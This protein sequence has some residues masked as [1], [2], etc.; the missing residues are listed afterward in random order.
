VYVIDNKRRKFSDASG[1]EDDERDTAAYSAQNTNI[2]A[3]DA[4]DSSGSSSDESSDDSDDED[5][6]AEL[7]R[8]LEKIRRERKEEQERRERE[9]KEA[10]MESAARA[11]MHG[12]PLIQHAG[13]ED[14]VVKKKWY[15]DTV[16]RN[17]AAN[18]PQYKK[19]FVNDTVRNDFH[20]KFI[21]K[22]VK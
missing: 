1:E 19:R 8:E 22:Y 6:T 10:E 7:E 14:F 13:A 3:L 5:E 9:R 11:V 4:D 16:F 20:R 2:N 21:N 12:N 17:Q 18:E 15:E